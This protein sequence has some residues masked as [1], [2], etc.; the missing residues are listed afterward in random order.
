LVVTADEMVAV[1]PGLGNGAFGEA[2]A[3]L[4]I[5]DPGNNIFVA[6]FNRDGRPDIAACAFGGT[7]NIALQDANGQYSD[8]QTPEDGCSVA[9]AGDVNGDGN[10]DLLMLTQVQDNRFV[11]ISVLLGKGDGTFAPPAIIGPV[12]YTFTVGDFN[13]DGKLDIAFCNPY[14]G[15]PACPEIMFGNGDGTFGPPVSLNVTTQGYL[16]A[17]GDFNN[18]GKLDLA[19]AVQQ[20]IGLI[21]LLGKGDGTFTRLPVNTSIQ[22]VPEQIVIGDFNGDGSTDLLI[23][24]PELQILLGLGDGQFVAQPGSLPG[25]FLVD[26]QAFAGDLNVYGKLDIVTLDVW[27]LAGPGAIG[28][29]LNKTP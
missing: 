18:D 26:C 27:D 19:I 21:V 5:V 24:T 29:L 15:Q 3:T 13:S 7:L 17:S 2:V 4:D 20:P 9:W 28:V 23:V 25:I 10:P 12:P 1:C 16:I 22:S 8:L 11:N 14:E 6:D